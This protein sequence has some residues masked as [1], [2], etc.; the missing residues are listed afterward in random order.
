MRPTLALLAACGALTLA[1]SGSSST[2]STAT[3]AGSAAAAAD[4]ST[5]AATSAAATPATC[6]ATAPAKATPKTYTAPPKP[7]FDG[8]ATVVMTT[9]CG[10]I[11]MTLDPT[12]G[13]KVEAACAGLVADGFYDGLTFHRVVP[14]FVIQ[15][16]DPQ[17][18]GSGGPGFNV[19]QAPPADYVYKDG[20]VAMA[21]TGSDPAGAA[22]SQF[23]VVS[24]PDGAAGLGQPG[25]PPLYA[26]VGHVTDAA[27]K[28]TVARIDALGLPDA[29]NGAP[30][31][32]VYIL[33]AVLQHG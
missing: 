2:A 15:G 3:P 30:S 5:P 25:T 23:F 16:G 12:V 32:P 4:T 31:Q 29:P 27:S 13:G 33:K 7:P 20:D 14:Q 18:D 28:A 17:G 9:S 19:V 6:A 26:V 11:T 8:P 1:A 10:T 21:K 22:G 24:S